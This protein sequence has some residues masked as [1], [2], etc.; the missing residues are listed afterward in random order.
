MRMFANA[1]GPTFDT[2]IAVNI[3]IGG[4]FLY[5]NSKLNYTILKE[6]VGK[7]RFWFN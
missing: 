7:S 5:F 1:Y 4:V 6:F 3:L 2:Q